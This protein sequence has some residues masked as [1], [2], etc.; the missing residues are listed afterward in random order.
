MYEFVDYLRILIP[1]LL[2]DSMSSAP[3]WPRMLKT[4]KKLLSIN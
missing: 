4:T 2:P 3:P 1:N